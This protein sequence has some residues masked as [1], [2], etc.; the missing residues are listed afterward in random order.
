[1]SS[2]L[3]VLKF[4]ELTEYSLNYDNILFDKL[5]KRALVFNVDLADC[6]PLA[7][8]NIF[9]ATVRVFSSRISEQVTEIKPDLVP[10]TGKIISLAYLA[11]AGNEHYDGTQ[12][13]A[14]RMTQERWNRTQSTLV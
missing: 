9:S 10:T 8:A 5:L 1:M 3:N 13:R 12:Q 2:F 7:I 11:C 14:I 4:R 6:L